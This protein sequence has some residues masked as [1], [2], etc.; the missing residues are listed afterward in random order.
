M[1]AICRPTTTVL[2]IEIKGK[3]GHSLCGAIEQ[4]FPGDI[5][6]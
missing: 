4:V 5:Q 3:D 1:L 6:S 2:R